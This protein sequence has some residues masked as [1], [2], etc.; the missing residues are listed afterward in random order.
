MTPRII[1]KMRIGT[2]IAAANYPFVRPVG[3]TYYFIISGGLVSTGYGGTL[4]VLLVSMSFGNE[5]IGSGS[6]SGI[7]GTIIILAGFLG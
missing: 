3:R 1:K 5:S 6:E 4:L 7:I 2:T